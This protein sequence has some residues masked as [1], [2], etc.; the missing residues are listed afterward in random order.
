MQVNRPPSDHETALDTSVSVVGQQCR[1]VRWPLSWAVFAATNRKV[2]V[3]EPL[4][5]CSLSLSDYLSLFLSTAVSTTER[6]RSRQ[7]GF[8]HTHRK[9]RCSVVSDPMQCHRNHARDRQTDTRHMLYAFRHGRG[10]RNNTSSQCSS[11]SLVMNLCDLLVYL[12]NL[13]D[14]DQRCF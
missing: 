11:S 12:I 14:S 9:D 4:V 5:R 3:A 6:Q 7:A 2:A 13:W 1:Y 8:F 10:Q